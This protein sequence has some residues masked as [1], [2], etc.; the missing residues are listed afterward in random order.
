M[1]N[2]RLYNTLWSRII[3]VPHPFFVF[4]SLGNIKIAG[5]KK[6]LNDLLKIGDIIFLA[7]I[8]T[9]YSFT[10]YLHTK[11][12]VGRK[13]IF[14]PANNLVKGLNDYRNNPEGCR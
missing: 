2:A 14:R 12:M 10:K 1:H 6:L 4:A 7:I 9:K 5:L 13:P 8:T 3:V 11:Y